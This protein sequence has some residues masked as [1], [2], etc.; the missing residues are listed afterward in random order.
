[1][2]QTYYP[3]RQRCKTCRKGFGELVIAGQFCSYKCGGFPQ[4][5]KTITEAPRG[6][7]REVNGTWGYKTKFKSATEVPSKY[8]NDPSTNIYLCDN[9][10]HYHIGHSRPEQQPE[11]LVR[12]V[13]SY[14]ELASVIARIFVQNNLDKKLV[15]KKMGVPIIR[16]TEVI[17][18]SPKVSPVLL[19]KLLNFL[20]L[21]V[22]LTQ[23]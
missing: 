12:Y 20:R 3:V 16:I 14:E 9:C 4:P 15:A 11:K 6:C 19:F 18:G 2:S 13:S 23:Y 1:M 10:R 22:E 5:A 21:R 8:Q 7:K 17:N